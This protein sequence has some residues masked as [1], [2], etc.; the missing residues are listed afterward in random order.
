[1]HRYPRR[2]GGVG[3]IVT[4]RDGRAFTAAHCIA[5]VDGAPGVGLQA[6][7]RRFVVVR[8]WS[9]RRLDLAVLLAMTGRGRASAAARVV[10]RVGAQ[11]AFYGHTGGRFQARRATVTA[12]TPTTAVATVHHPRGVCGNDSGGPV[13]VG[14]LLAG[15]V[16][17]RTGET[18]SHTCSREVVITRLD[19]P[20][21]R[22]RIDRAFARR[23]ARS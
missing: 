18:V 17:A 4:L 21:V 8:R 19:A 11:V 6:L 3:T 14:G 22:A 9:P 7:G 1:V 16:A 13:F 20:A 5:E 23:T 15:V 12:V 2:F 10:L